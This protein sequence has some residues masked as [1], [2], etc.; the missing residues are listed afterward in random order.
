MLTPHPLRRPTISDIDP[1]EMKSLLGVDKPGSSDNTPESIDELRRRATEDA[2][3]SASRQEHAPLVDY[4]WGRVPGSIEEPSE[5]SS[6]NTE[7][8]LE[9]ETSIPQV[10]AKSSLEAAK[11]PNSFKNLLRPRWLFPNFKHDSE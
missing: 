2:A 1:Q 5:N 8:E 10:T 11:D 7:E 6:A 9:L 4:Y 3:A